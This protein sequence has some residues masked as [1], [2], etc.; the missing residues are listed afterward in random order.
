MADLIKEMRDILE[1]GNGFGSSIAWT[2]PKEYALLNRATDRIEE[3]EGH[4]KLYKA[5]LDAEGLQAVII[6]S[7]KER[8]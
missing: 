8:D 3:L 4:I 2:W 6:T 1:L 7:K 5:A